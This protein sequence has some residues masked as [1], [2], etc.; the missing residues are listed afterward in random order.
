MT[1]RSIVLVHPTG[2][3]A[4]TL[5]PLAEALGEGARV[6]SYTRLGWDGTSPPRREAYYSEHACQLVSLL[7][8][9]TEPVE[10][11]AWS[12]GGFV[13]LHAALT[14]KDL[15]SRLHLYEVPFASSRDNDVRQLTQFVRM[16]AWTA[17]RSPVRARS[18]FWTMVSQRRRGGN[19]FKALPPQTRSLLLRQEGPLLR[20]VLAGTGEELMSELHRISIPVQVI[21]GRE[22]GRLAQAAAKRLVG[23]V[24]M[25]QLTTLEAGDHLA[26]LLSPQRVA[27]AILEVSDV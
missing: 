22:S 2:V 19:G 13:A 7:R 8:E 5:S 23:A 25:A 10:V 17:L 15:I 6:I 11:F 9:Q 26:P 14:A 21:V 12:S 1:R 4:Q 3:V 18:A 27:R 20:E 24:K 16:L